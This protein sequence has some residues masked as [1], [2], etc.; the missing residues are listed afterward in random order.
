MVPHQIDQDKMEIL[1]NRFALIKYN[2]QI[3]AFDEID[4][5]RVFSYT[6]M[7]LYENK[8]TNVILKFTVQC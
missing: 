7:K 5:T 8:Y 1:K 6:I 2:T 4:D 3:T